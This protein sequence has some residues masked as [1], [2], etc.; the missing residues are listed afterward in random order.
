MNRRTKLLALLVIAAVAAFV[1]DK[2]FVSLWWDPWKK[3]SEETH[4]T[5]QEVARANRI[6]SRQHAAEEGWKKIRTLLDKPRTPEVQ[7]HFVS[8][9]ND[10]CSRVGVSLS[11]TS[12]PVPQ[13]QGDFKEYVYETK[14]KLTWAQFV[15]LLLELHNS[16][17]FLKPI[18][19]NISS[20]YEKED[21]LD[22]DL[23]VSTIEYAPVPVRAGK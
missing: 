11:A 20:Q 16:K 3:L 2:L 14:F 23:K 9:L 10:I 19:I 8:H 7:T 22:L 6:F 5:E 4:K 1:L 21:R 13:P 15:D 17:E 12:N 18:R